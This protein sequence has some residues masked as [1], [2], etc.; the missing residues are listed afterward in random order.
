MLPPLKSCDSLLLQNTLVMN[1]SA[2]FFNILLDAALQ[3]IRKIKWTTLQYAQQIYFKFVSIY[4]VSIQF[5]ARNPQ[6][7]WTESCRNRSIHH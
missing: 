1:A 3:V 4:L 7:D 5:V 6:A 2:I